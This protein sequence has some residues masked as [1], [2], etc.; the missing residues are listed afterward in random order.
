MRFLYCFSKLVHISSSEVMNDVIT[1]E[2]GADNTMH[3]R[4]RLNALTHHTRAMLC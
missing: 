3:L 2:K 4:D 1:L